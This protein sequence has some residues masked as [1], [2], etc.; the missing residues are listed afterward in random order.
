MFCAGQY[1]EF[2]D[3]AECL[4]GYCSGVEFVHVVGWNAVSGMALSHIPC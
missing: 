4:F 1:T 3:S 2:R